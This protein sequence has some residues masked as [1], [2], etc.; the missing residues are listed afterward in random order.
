MA[1]RVLFIAD[2]FGLSEAVNEGVERA[3]RDG[4]LTGASLMVGGAAAQDAVRR[5]QRNPGLAVGLHLVVVE[6]PAVLPAGTIPLL[7]GPD[8]GFPSD[9]VAMGW[10]Y[11]FRPEV[12]RQLLAEIAA[13]FAAFA[14]TGLPLAHVDAHK[15]MH[16]H[17]TVG[18]AMV[19]EAAARGRSVRV[20]VPCEPAAVLARLGEWPGVGARLLAQ[21]TRLL[22]H[23]VRRAGL[24][25]AQATFGL[26]WSGHFRS[27]KL[28][29]L[30]PLLPEGVSEIYFHPAQGRDATLARLMPDYEHE[31]ELAALCS[32]AVRAVL[33]QEGIARWQPLAPAAAQPDRG[34]SCSTSA[35]Q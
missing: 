18:A 7:L 29:R 11:F 19:R 24:P 33:A 31:A 20:R 6:G 3:F 26:A 17:P 8:G 34:S 35:A 30:L 1:R 23:Q 32:S 2:D 15:H 12:R 13:Q 28:L 10:R 22:R 14:A 4:V 9:Q 21:W 16:L 5:A 25:C 27:E